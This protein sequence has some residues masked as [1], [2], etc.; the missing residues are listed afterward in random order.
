MTYITPAPA[1]GKT[2][3]M[4]QTIQTP[5]AN[6]P[7]F[8]AW[9]TP[10]GVPPFSRIAPEHF[11][12]AYACAL[13][14]HEAEVAAIAAATAPPN[15]ENTIA[16]MELSGRALE[17]VGNVFWLLAGANT[18]DA[19]LEIER[20]LSP[21]IARHWNKI[22]TN[23]ALFRRIDTLMRDADMLGLDAEQKRVP[24][25]TARAS[26]APA[27]HSMATRKTS[28]PNHR[29]A[30]RARHRVQPECAR[31]RAGLYA[32]ARAAKPTGR[33]AAFHA[34]GDARGST[35]TRTRRLCRDAVAL[36]R[37]AVP[38][39]LRPARSARKAL[40]R[41]HHARR[42]WRADRQQGA[43]CRNG[44]VARRARAASRLCRLRSLPARRRHGEDAGRRR[45]RSSM[46]CGPPRARGR[47]PTAM[48][49][50]R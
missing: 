25:A 17:R 12:E 46:R 24:S 3:A 49:C 18:N 35:R 33:P 21:Q 36:E 50:R 41:L 6:N 5:T 39:I 27:P 45:A 32:A 28:R 23:A 26:A 40:S 11:R 42:Q 15:F 9:T 38:A 34:R 29:A 43:D 47:S 14:E 22:H 7:F 48:P 10:D 30:R 2:P 20:E 16:A 1:I 44:S 4:P 13:A 37:R 31:R 8:E 19:L